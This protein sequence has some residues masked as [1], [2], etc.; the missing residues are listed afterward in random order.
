MLVLSVGIAGTV[1]IYKV[2]RKLTELNNNNLIY[3]K[4][5]QL[6]N[7][8][9]FKIYGIVMNAEKNK[10]ENKI[11]FLS[12]YI[13]ENDDIIN[14]FKKAKSTKKEQNSVLQVEYEYNDWKNDNEKIMEAVK[15]QDYDKIPELN[16]EG[17]YLMEKLTESV[18]NV[19]QDMLKQGEDSNNYDR[20]TYDDSLPEAV[21]IF[22][23]EVLISVFMCVVVCK[24]LKKQE[25]IFKIKHDLKSGGKA[26]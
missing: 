19:S 13:K 25:N 9:I 20:N 10:D 17:T 11:Y 3:I 5:V 16:K 7:N 21:I 2:S 26:I 24:T 8:N 4:D 6:L 23:L 18:Q 14:N 1:N 15:L 12:T 22:I